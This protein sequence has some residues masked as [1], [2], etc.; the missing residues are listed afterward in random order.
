M[1][2]KDAAPCYGRAMGSWQTFI[3]EMTKALFSWPV[4]FLIVGL[5]LRRPVLRLIKG[6]KLAS[7]SGAGVQATFVRE[8]LREAETKAK[9]LPGTPNKPLP[10][11]QDTMTKVEKQP[12][13]ELKN[14]VVEFSPRPRARV[15]TAWNDLARVIRSAVEDAGLSETVALDIHPTAMAYALSAAEVINDETVD[16]V[17][18][19]AELHYDLINSRANRRDAIAYAKLCAD[20][21]ASITSQTNAFVHLGRG[22]KP[23]DK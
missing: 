6:L 13:S 8:E 14:V 7:V 3:I 17:A 21:G 9:Q 11:V 2:A 5:K 18:R 19:A 22:T 12:A 4:A 23:L 20:I 1:A 10:P 16:A 15:T